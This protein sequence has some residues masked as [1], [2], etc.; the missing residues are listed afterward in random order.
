MKKGLLKLGVLVS[1][2]AIAVTTVA[3]APQAEENY[4]QVVYVDA[5]VESGGAGTKTAPFGTLQAAKDYVRKINKN[6]EGDIF[7]DIAPGYYYVG[8]TLN[9]GKADGGT[10]GYDVIWG[11]SSEERPLISGGKYVTGEW[12][13]VDSEKNIYG[14]PYQGPEYVRQIYVND[15]RAQ[16]AWTEGEYELIN[17]SNAVI[18]K[19]GYTTEFTD[20]VNWRNI[21]DVEFSFVKLWTNSCCPVTSVKQREDGKV[22]VFMDP[23]MWGQLS[24][25][26]VNGKVDM[27]WRIE[28][29][30]ELMD[31]PGEFYYDRELKMLYYIP[32][33]GDDMATAEVIVPFTDTLMTIGGSVA[34]RTEHIVFKNLRFSHSAWYTPDLLR[35][36][37]DSQNNVVYGGAESRWLPGAI[38]IE[39]GDY[40]DFYE[41]EISHMGQSG[42]NY[43]KASHDN[44]FIGNHV[45]DIAAG[46]THFGSVLST[47]DKNGIGVFNGDISEDVYNLEVRNNWVHDFGHSYRDAAG[48]TVGYVSFAN[49][50]HNEVGNAPYSGF[51]VNWGWDGSMVK[52]RQ[53]RDN[54][55]EYNYIYNTM[56]GT[57]VNDGAAVYTLGTTGGS[58]DN[59]N[60][61]SYN[62]IRQTERT[63]GAGGL[64]TD[65]GSSYYQLK[66]NVVDFYDAYHNEITNQFL[67]ANTWTSTISFIE[68]IDCYTTDNPGEISDRGTNTGARGTVRVSECNWNDDAKKIINESGLEDKYRKMWGGAKT[69]GFE[70]L[71]LHNGENGYV[72]NDLQDARAMKIDVGETRHFTYTAHN[73]WAEVVPTSQYSVEFKSLTPDIIEVTNNSVTGKKAG[74]GYIEFTVTYDGGKTQTRKVHVMCGDNLDKV[75]FKDRTTKLFLDTEIKLELVCTT[76]LGNT[77]TDYDVEYTTSNPAIATVS[78]DG[79]VRAVAEG[80]VQISAVVTADGTTVTETRTLTCAKLGKFDTTGLKVTPINDIFNDVEG[81]H[82]G[83]AKD[84]LN[85]TK[86]DILYVETP[87]GFAMYKNKTYDNE[88]LSF[89]L[90]VTGPDD[91]WPTIVFG[92]KS[93]PNVNP[94]GGS[95]DAYLICIKPT[96]IELQR[97]NKG[98]SRTMLYG[99]YG[100]QQ[101]RFGKMPN[102]YITYGKEANIQIGAFT[103]PDGGTRLIMNVNGYNVFDVVDDFVNNFQGPYYFGCINQG[104]SFTFTRAAEIATS[105]DDEKKDE[106]LDIN[107]H[108]AKSSI[109]KLRDAGY[110]TGI[111]KTTFA[112]NK[113][114]SRAEFLAIVTRIL[115]ITATDP[116]SV[117]AD[118]PAWGWYAPTFAAALEAEILDSHFVENNCIRPDAP[119]RRDEMAAILVSAYKYQMNDYVSAADISTFADGST[120]E[121][122][123]LG[124]MKNAVGGGLMYG[125]D[126][127]HLNPLGTAT[128]AE[129]AAMLQRFAEMVE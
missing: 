124:Y 25:T 37:N 43:V 56:H 3:I 8:E 49:F 67:W 50:M 112:P 87:S 78:K 32:R 23:S 92:Q 27:P 106:F 21:S 55:I 85:N 58:L 44:E 30:Y 68:Y 18:T 53:S 93:A 97:F 80:D 120:V 74:N 103:N 54:H 6:M 76:A 118:V 17:S 125:D 111:N 83:N 51:H 88:L 70:K 107:G 39:Y 122:W 14:I 71:I 61:V 47:S 64:Y 42:V 75:A 116:A 69:K 115:R 20:M 62:Y 12:K 104:G 109:N 34:E 101:G 48:I 22:D 4:Q 13:V 38:N 46:G 63:G 2:V 60:T 65:E 86:R 91:G 35:G 79:V 7:V 28:N 119:I 72:P 5:S 36:W 102:T 16:R 82:K 81:W 29:A 117:Y 114:I 26:K 113:T 96:E 19:D 121:P 127:N 89:N 128:R 15:V 59:P 126:T 98:I 10:N 1:A 40:I 11:S 123:A 100:A 31:T 57:P 73:T 24:V 129:A 84:F 41:C 52:G 90:T 33:A 110:V 9:F 108:W 95:A 45:Y 105:D 99:T 66:K 77:V 94:V